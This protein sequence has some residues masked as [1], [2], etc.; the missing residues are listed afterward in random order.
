MRTASDEEPAGG[1][2]DCFCNCQLSIAKVD[3]PE[4]GNMEGEKGVS[5]RGRS[6]I[7]SAEDG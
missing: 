4:N 3:V 5:K 1:I 6:F 7:S 2:D